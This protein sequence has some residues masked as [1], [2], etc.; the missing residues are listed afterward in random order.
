[1]NRRFAI[2]SLVFAVTVAAVSSYNSYFV[3]F[4]A[5][6]A[7]GKYLQA[8]AVVNT[9]GTVA[10]AGNISNSTMTQLA[11]DPAILEMRAAMTATTI[12]KDQYAD[13]L[14]HIAKCSKP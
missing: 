1:M 10:V 4:D 2:W 7:H 3:G 9:T 13:L 6:V 8:V 12:N 11:T 14:A 5:G